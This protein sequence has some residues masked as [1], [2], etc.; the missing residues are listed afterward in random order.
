MTQ[1]LFE[2]AA[3]DLV[4]QPDPE[5]D[6]E[7]EFVGEGKK[8]KDTK[9]LAYSAAVK[10]AFIEQLK[11]ETARL[12]GEL[13]KQKT[14][15]EVLTAIEQKSKTKAPEAE[16][17]P[18]ERPDG[19]VAP[20]DLDARIKEAAASV[21]KNLTK[22]Q[23]A[24]KNVNFVMTSLEEAWGPEFRN[25]LEAE[26]KKL[27]L[28]RDFITMLARERPE[29]LL[30]LIG[31]KKAPATERNPT[32]PSGSVNTLALGTGSGTKEKALSYYTKLK[33]ENPSL[34]NS[35]AVQN[36]MHSQAL[37]LRAAFFDV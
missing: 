33:K 27:N 25:R 5:K 37:K 14:L 23:Q 24:E 12:R 9:A 16:G 18:A 22:E 13:S 36:E 30:A 20:E 34:Y 11:K 8:F 2:S 35:P 26:G 7:T 21:V 1:E 29:A 32:S 3:E 6:W 15:D 4:D 19:K 31:A 10:D 17:T 28:G